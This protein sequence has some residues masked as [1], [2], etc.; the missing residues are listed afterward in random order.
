[1]SG[2]SYETC[3]SLPFGDWLTCSG[4]A[5]SSPMHFTG[6]EHDAETGLDNFGA[7]YDASS[8]G[9]FLTPGWSSDPEAVPYAKLG[10]PQSL[11][12][13]AYVQNNPV[14]ALDL[15][16]HSQDGV[17]QAHGWDGIGNPV[18]SNNPAEDA[19]SPWTYQDD[20][21]VSFTPFDD[22]PKNQSS[23]STNAGTSTGDTT[24]S[25][26]SQSSTPEASLKAVDVQ[27]RR[28]PIH[29]LPE[30]QSGSRLVVEMIGLEVQFPFE[31]QHSWRRYVQPRG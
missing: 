15:D 12:L 1:M 7:R 18:S 16:G 31:E 8:L 4:G 17:M 5:D 9:R 27:G 2:A 22:G 3:T 20:G 26:G 21:T 25:R 30:L 24:T 11:N 29:D 23:A 10:N 19:D 28:D 14:N 13:Y 6:K